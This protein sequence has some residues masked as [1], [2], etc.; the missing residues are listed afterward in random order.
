M[1]RRR[2]TAVLGLALLG[3]ALLSL[4]GCE[5]PLL[6]GGMAQNFE[7]EKKIEVPAEYT[8]L[9]ERTVAILVSS[10][11]ST[12]YDHPM[13]PANVAFNV[14]SRIQ[15]NVPGVRVRDPRLVTQWQY[16]TPGW[17]S[18][19]LGD[20]AVELDVERV[21]VIDLYEFRLNPP[22]NRYIWDGVAAATIGIIEREAID[23]DQ[24]AETFSVIAKFPPFD[25]PR[26]SA[27][28]GQIMTG[29]LVRFV[30]RSAWL[31]YTHIE[32]KYPK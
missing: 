30:E 13:V 31:F 3:A 9:E 32:D 16:Q 18:M 25:L 15:S 7:R 26:D 19:P 23:P 29:L 11:M 14:A 28:E 17:T 21:V 5:V 8:G 4:G 22:G 27:N 20:I 24:Y 10:D 12:M 2:G 6:I 1:K